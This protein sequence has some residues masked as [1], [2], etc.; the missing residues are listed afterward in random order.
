VS[1]KD[2]FSSSTLIVFILTALLLFLA[3][4]A[5]LVLDQAERLQAPVFELAEDVGVTHVGPTPIGA[6]S[7]SD[8]FFVLNARCYRV[9]CDGPFVFADGEVIS[10]R[11][12]NRADLD[13]LLATQSVMTDSVALLLA[14][15]LIT[16][17]E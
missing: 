16:V 14:Q 4:A 9:V 6:G 8:E 11:W 17:A 12:V 15:G 3:P 5:R 10:A 2:L 1:R 7:F 13:D